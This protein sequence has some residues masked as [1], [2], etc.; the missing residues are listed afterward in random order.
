V[1]H[2]DPIPDTLANRARAQI[3]TTGGE[4]VRWAWHHI[5]LWGAIGPHSRISE[6]FGAFGDGTSICWPNETLI[7][8]QA[9]HLGEQTVI[10]P[11]VALSAGWFENEPMLPDR[12]I[13]IGDRCLI[14]RGSTV[15]GHRWIEIG[16]DVWTGH[17]V[18]ITDM[19]HGY[20][21]VERPISVQHQPEKGVY[22]GSGSWLG[23]GVTVLPGV[24]IGEHVVVGAGSVVT[25]SLP[26]F[27]V[28]VGSPARVIR[29]YDHDAEAWVPVTPP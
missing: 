6:D 29:R 18:H 28:A 27:S 23:H 22:I 2:R 7:N 25:Q 13:T 20:E 3:A 24:S 9:I 8:P 14:G 15:I 21:D 19:N 17:Y 5:R 1:I 16:D 4:V 26:D 12:V 10:A 11:H